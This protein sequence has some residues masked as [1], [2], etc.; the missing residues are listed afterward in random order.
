MSRGVIH[1]GKSRKRRKMKV[2]IGDDE[3]VHANP[4]SLAAIISG[5]AQGLLYFAAQKVEVVALAALRP[6][7][8]NARTHSH[9]QIRKIAESVKRFGFCN[10]ILIDDDHQII[11]GHGRVEAAKFLGLTRVPALRLSHLSDA[12]KRAYIIADN[13]LAE[14]ASWDRDVLAI[15]LEGLR[16]LNF[17]VELTGFDIGEV[18]IILDDADEVS[19][20][21]AASGEISHPAVSQGGDQWVLGEHRL[22]CGDAE[23]E[24]AYVSADI[25]IRHWQR[26]TGKSAMLVGTTKSFDDIKNDRANACVRP[27]ASTRKSA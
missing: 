1:L 18:N 9:T 8:A 4:A 2:G 27:N 17:N 3:A 15:E 11:A 20:P 23:N 7:K 26:F 5:K 19:R 10:P 22:V 6:Y 12:E 14:L 21:N 13:R 24:L 16:D 25:V